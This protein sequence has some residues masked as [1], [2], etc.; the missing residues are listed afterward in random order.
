MSQTAPEQLDKASP[1][2]VL[3]LLEEAK[4][5]VERA[6]TRRNAIQAKLEASRQLYADALKEAQGLVD[7]RREKKR[8]EDL[9]VPGTEVNLDLL[10]AILV[11]EEAENAKAVAE[12]VRAADHYESVIARIEKA[13]SDPEA[14]NELLLTLK[15]A[16]PATS[17]A[18][19]AAEVAVVEA[20]QQAVQF[21]EDDI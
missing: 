2:V 14:L 7:A 18:P 16:T 12:F 5:R 20:P 3:Q 17:A 8:H 6:N 1:Q 15:P 19:A 9:L 10:R 21:N 4:Q 11:R 13:L